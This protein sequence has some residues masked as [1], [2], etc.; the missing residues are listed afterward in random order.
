MGV[1]LQTYRLRIGNFGKYISKGSKSE[2]RNQ[3]YNH[4]VSNGHCFLFIML[5]LSLSF[6]LI[7][8]QTPR[9]SPSPTRLPSLDSS[10][11]APAPYLEL[12]SFIF[13]GSKLA[14]FPPYHTTVFSASLACCIPPW[15][16]GKKSKS[17]ILN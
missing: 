1:S 12:S 15:T 8:H 7:Y 9:P 4:S 6:L 10:S 16:G 17:L 2:T 11:G 13:K 5:Y 14:Q 3:A